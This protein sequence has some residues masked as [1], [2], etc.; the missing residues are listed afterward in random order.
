MRKILFRELQ[1]YKTPAKTPYKTDLV[2]LYKNAENTYK[3]KN[4]QKTDTRTLHVNSIT[5]I[6]TLLNQ[7]NIETSSI[8]Y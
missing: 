3:Q 8:K 6:F 4:R 7:V 5:I 2:V 1:R